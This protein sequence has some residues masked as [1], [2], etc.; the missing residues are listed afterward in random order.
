VVA[1]ANVEVR[2]KWKGQDV[3]R[4]IRQVDRDAAR[5][6][7]T[8]RRMTPILRSVGA[9]MGLA[10]GTQMVKQVVGMADAW[11][12]YQ[13]RIRLFTGS[14]KELA[15]V[16]DR[17]FK[18]SQR[19]FTSMGS[20]V[21]LYQKFSMSNDELK[22]SQEELGG[23]IETVNQTLL[24]SGGS[25]E[26][27]NAAVIQLGQGLASGTLRG[28]ELNSV[29]EQAP[30]LARALAAGMNIPIG[31]L[32]E[33][34]AAG[35]ITGKKVIE[36]LQSQ[37]TTV[38]AEAATMEATVSMAWVRLTDSVGNYLDKLNEVSGATSAI[39]S[40]MKALA[41][42]I[43]SLPDPEEIKQGFQTPAARMATAATAGMIA[44]APFGGPVGAA[45]G[46]TAATAAQ[47]FIL[48]DE[49][50]A[51]EKKRVTLSQRQDPSS[52]FFTGMQEPTIEQLMF[53]HFGPDVPVPPAPPPPGRFQGFGRQ[54]PADFLPVT[55]GRPDFRAMEDR[56]RESTMP[57]FRPFSI[58]ERPTFEG[59]EQDRAAQRALLARFEAAQVDTDLPGS[60]RRLLEIRQELE[61]QNTKA[62][63]PGAKLW[64]E[65]LG[66]VHKAELQQHDAAV[67]RK[68]DL[69]DGRK[70]LKDQAEAERDRL[71]AQR[72]FQRQVA[73]VFHVLSQV[74]PELA[75]FSRLAQDLAT[76]DHLG[77][78]VNG[79]TLL[80]NALGDSSDAHREEMRAIERASA[81]RRQVAHESNRTA[82]SMLGDTKE[83]IDLTKKVIEP[84]FMAL[85][86]APGATELERLQGFLESYG[87]T[88][89]SS[90]LALI[91]TL[92]HM[93]GP[94]L[95]PN[96][97]NADGTRRNA[98][99]LPGSAGWVDWT[100]KTFEDVFGITSFEFTRGLESIFGG[101]T[102][103]RDV[104]GQMYDIRDG[105]LD[106]AAAAEE[107]TGP[108][109]RAVTTTFDVQEMALR[110]QAQGEFAAAGGNVGAQAVVMAGLK[111]SID[112]LARNERE[113]L[114]LALAAPAAQAD[115]TTAAAGGT[116]G[117]TGGTQTTV[118]VAGGELQ[119]LDAADLVDASKITP[120]SITW[121]SVVRMV[122]NFAERHAP[123]HW[124]RLVD[125]PEK[126][127]RYH[128]SWYQTIRMRPGNDPSNY[129]HTPRSWAD[130]VR[131]PT[132]LDR[133][134]YD[135]PEVIDMRDKYGVSTKKRAMV[136]WH[137]VIATAAPWAGRPIKG[138]DWTHAI[139]IENKY[140]V[141]TKK[142]AMA[143]WQD[144][145]ATAAPWKDK[146]ITDW[147]WPHAI[148]IGNKYGLSSKRSFTGWHDV[149]DVNVLN[150][151]D[152][153]I[154]RDWYQAVEFRHW[155]Y[156]WHQRHRPSHW[157]HLVDLTNTAPIQV[158][159]SDIITFTGSKKK[160]SLSDVF[161]LS[162]LEGIVT[163]IVSRNSN[164][165]VDPADMTW[166]ERWNMY[167]RISR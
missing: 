80:I 104:I 155:Y 79:I 84:F 1:T 11:K 139:E 166:E 70:A 23:V 47:L 111:D 127:Q 147:D 21:D 141:S 76:G 19:T 24:I 150:D 72:E 151:P 120:I 95:N 96:E 143:G 158:A 101:E 148:E 27:A 99:P 8:M 117:E 10:V 48:I 113:A 165:R 16:Q 125:I 163:G 78:A 93:I 37:A 15:E 114:R 73:G 39:A 160:I 87:D 94:Q 68:K 29:L 9:M 106:M 121:P 152:S 44:G 135:W 45:V 90:G 102:K 89:V 86:A 36:A 81:K 132:D 109:E 116:G 50:F 154:K 12:G 138:W 66:E 60:E 58:M 110:R 137:D 83:V 49:Y 156:S 28:E 6:K 30:R 77:A 69:V 100:P 17:L 98:V 71:K 55:G 149:I 124:S 92:E 7:E 140:G 85:D 61:M 57:R 146:P 56:F 128:R 22:L 144:V 115:D 75:K 167:N 122:P 40:S 136:G 108:L 145:I 43:N 62:T 129:P 103:I 34:G 59:T 65:T 13:N 161:D 130:L 3:Q 126:L 46:G 32:R 131:I 112:E 52:R 64:I 51:E 42:A 25:A 14:A 38:A 5:L 119:P 54:T 2:A 35:E 33:L 107:L 118:T 53:K 164:N 82:A 134:K 63:I 4:G 18:I 31:K 20:T 153:R 41:E 91:G 157:S 74:N 162:E 159:Y 26:S 97:F 142:R 67:Q 88:T 133:L 105:F 123:R